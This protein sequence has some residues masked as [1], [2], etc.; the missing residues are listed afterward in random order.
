MA[1]Y[2]AIV[3]EAEQ[4]GLFFVWFPDA[5]GCVADGKS[6]DEALDNA[7][8]ALSEWVQDELADGRAA[9]RPRTYRQIEKSGELEAARGAILAWVPLLLDTGKLVRANI[10]MDQGLLASIDEAAARRG[11]TRSAFLVAAARDKIKAGA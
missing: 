3:E 4:P 7:A 6:Q 5:P 8:E 10:S 11:V 9:P 2:L 1:R